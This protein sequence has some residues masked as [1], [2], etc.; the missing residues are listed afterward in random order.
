MVLYSYIAIVTIIIYSVFCILIKKFNKTQ[1]LKFIPW[2]I[3]IEDRVIYNLSQYVN[4]ADIVWLKVSIIT[5]VIIIIT[6]IYYIFDKLYYLIS[7]FINR[8]NIIS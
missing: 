8:K 2:L 3:L 7:K 1:Y 5:I 6:F 4:E